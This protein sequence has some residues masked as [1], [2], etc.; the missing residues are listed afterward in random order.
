V[1]AELGVGATAPW[2]VGAVMGTLI[3][4]L[5]LITVGAVLVNSATVTSGQPGP[6]RPAR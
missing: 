6:G 3:V 5:L 1:E 4:S 2:L